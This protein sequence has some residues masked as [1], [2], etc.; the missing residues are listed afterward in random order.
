[1]RRVP[2]VCPPGLRRA[3]CSLACL[4]RKSS[5]LQDILDFVQKQASY[6]FLKQLYTKDER[7]ARIEEYHRRIGSMVAAFQ[8]RCPQQPNMPA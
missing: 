6:N 2:L 3:P 4:S 1:M 5:L 7:I 8:V